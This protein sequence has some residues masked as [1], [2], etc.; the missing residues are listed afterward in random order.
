VRSRGAP[1]LDGQRAEKETDVVG[2]S[3]E[4]SIFVF[5]LILSW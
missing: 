4:I 3:V 5:S 2:Q 1:T